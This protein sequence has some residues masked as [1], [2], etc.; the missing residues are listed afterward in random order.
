MIDRPTH[1]AILTPEALLADLPAPIV[2]RRPLTLS[3][4]IEPGL[5]AVQHHCPLAADATVQR[6]RTGPKHDKHTQNQ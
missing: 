1:S 3:A 2:A 4:A 6:A 5:L